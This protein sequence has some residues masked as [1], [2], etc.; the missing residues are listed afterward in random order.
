MLIALQF[1]EGDLDLAEELIN[2]WLKVD[3]GSLKKH[4]LLLLFSRRMDRSHGERLARLAFQLFSEVHIHQE[5]TRI[6]GWP[7]GANAFW[8]AT[9]QWAAA[10]KVADVT[11]CMEPDAVPTCNDWADIIE[12]EWLDAGSP[13]VMG[14]Y[15]LHP[16]PHIV[17]NLLTRTDIVEKL[18]EATRLP[19]GS[20]PWDL[21]LYSQ[22]KPHAVA[23]DSIFSHWRMKDATWEE[24]LKPRTHPE[25]H[26]RAGIQYHPALFHG[27]KDKEVHKQCPLLGNYKRLALRERCGVSPSRVQDEEGE[28]DSDWGEQDTDVA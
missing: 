22:F 3:R 27:I 23:A 14:C 28:P 10:N 20:K 17:G 21:V 16:I 25:K 4:Q 26:P 7:M 19:I 6:T 11:L 5:T 2:L 13:L 8:W 18:P 15:Q 24:I 9:V 1:Y 12:Q